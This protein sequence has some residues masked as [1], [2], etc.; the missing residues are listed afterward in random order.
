MRA[1]GRHRPWHQVHPA[2][3]DMESIRFARIPNPR[4][5]SGSA[6]VARALD[7]EVGPAEP[8][9][10]ILK[11]VVPALTSH[12]ASSRAEVAG[13]LMGS[14][15]Q[16][17]DGTL[18]VVRHSVPADD[19][20]E[21]SGTHV[22][23]RAAAWDSLS[24]A[25]DASGESALVVGWYHSHPSLGAFFSSTDRHTQQ[26]FFREPWQIG[27]VVDPVRGEQKAFQGPMA[28]PLDWA[29]IHAIATALD[30]ELSAP[31]APVLP[32]E[33]PA[34]VPEAPAPCLPSEA[35]RVAPRAVL[36]LAIVAVLVVI[37]VPY[38]RRRLRG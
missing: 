33:E 28:D 2:V 34:R 6:A 4:I 23:F 22:T 8:T 35:T 14:V 31:A 27:I 13:L 17:E 10:A 11:D 38:L 21:T 15:W 24:R 26:S 19:Q 32:A 1:L 5:R 3:D 25:V 30:P 16:D 20:V 9:V 36:A 7:L 37:V 29:A 18:I 12:A